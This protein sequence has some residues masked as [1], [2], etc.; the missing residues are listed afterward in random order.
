MEKF[1]LFREKATEFLKEPNQAMFE[2]ES[3]K[4]QKLEKETQYNLAYFEVTPLA[5]KHDVV[6]TK[7]LKVFNF[8]KKKLIDFEIEKAGWDWENNGIF[9]FILKKRQINPFVI[10]Q[11]PPLKMEEAVKAFQKKNKNTYE[12]R[13]KL[14]V[15]TP[16]K[17]YRLPDFLKHHLND[18]YVKERVKLVRKILVG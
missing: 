17:H 9:Y 10:K 13:G 8:M 1:F 5:G 11:G 15:K 7:L 6:G 4:F 14:W 2:K 3:L 12:E 16:I 18:S